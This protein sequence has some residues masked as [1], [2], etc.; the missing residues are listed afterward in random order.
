DYKQKFPEDERYEEPSPAARV[1]RTSLGDCAVFYVE[2]VE[3]WRDRLDI[4]LVFVSAY[5]YKYISSSWLRS[6]Q[7]IATVRPGQCV[8]CRAAANSS[9]M[10]DVPRSDLTPFSNS[11]PTASDSCIINCLW[12]TGISFSMAIALFVLTKRWIHKYMAVPCRTPQDRCRVRQFRH[13]ALRQ[14]RV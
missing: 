6:I 10:N 4:L 3:G 8:A 2:M 14:W 13:T 7:R 5:T 1:W 11:H 12:F 9:L